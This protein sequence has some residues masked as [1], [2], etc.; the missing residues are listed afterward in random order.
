MMRKILVYSDCPYKYLGT[1]SKYFTSCEDGFSTNLSRLMLFTKATK[2]K[3]HL[4][5][6]VNGTINYLVISNGN[7][8]M[9]DRNT[10]INIKSDT[11]QC[12]HIVGVKDRIIFSKHQYKKIKV[13]KTLVWYIRFM[14]KVRNKVKRAIGRTTRQQNKHELNKWVS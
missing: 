14:K 9:G 11:N 10:S 2:F 12:S 5:S 8:T 6:R 7:L 1:Y 13:S 4:F 3:V